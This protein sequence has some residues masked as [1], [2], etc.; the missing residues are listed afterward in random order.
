MNEEGVENQLPPGTEPGVVG[1]TGPNINAKETQETAG[2]APAPL[3]DPKET[4]GVSPNPEDD[5][6]AAT[7]I[8]DE[9]KS[10]AGEPGMDWFE[11]LE[12]DDDPDTE[13]L[14]GE[15]ESVAG[16]ERAMKKIYM[17]QSHRRK[18][19]H[20]D[21][22]WEDCPVLGEG[23]KRKEVVRRS[24]SS[25]GQKDVYYLGP[26]GER[27]RSR[28]ELTTVLQG[29][30]DLTSFDYKSGKFYDGDA[31]P[32]RVRNRVKRKYRERSSSES[33]WM[34]RGDGAETP[35]SYHRLTPTPGPKTSQQNQTNVYTNNVTGA[36]QQG[37]H[38]EE[39]LA[40]EKIRLP[41]P[42]SSRTLPLPSIK[43]EFGSEDS[44]LDC[45]RCGST[46]SGTWYDKQRKRPCCPTCWALSKAKVHPMIRFRKWIPC[47]QCVGCHNSVN[48]GQCA[49][50]KHGLQSPEAKKRLCRK[51]RCMC[52]IRKDP[53]SKF[54]SQMP[55]DD[56]PEMYDDNSNFQNE[57]TDSQPSLKSSDTEN[58]SVNMDL[59]ADL[60]ADFNMDLDE[61]EMSTDDDDDWHKKRK[62]RSCGEC[63]ACLCRKDC[64]TCDFCI[65][66][67]KFGGSNKKR[68]KCRL[69]QCQRQAMRH[70]LPFQMGEIEHGPDGTLPGRPKPQYTYSRKSSFKKNRGPNTSL[71]LTDNEDDEINLQALNHSDYG[72]RNGLPDR[73]PHISNHNYSQPS[74]QSQWDAERSHTGRNA[75]GVEE[76]EED[77]PMITQIFSLADNPNESSVDNENQL[78][79]LLH[80]L[81]LTI[82]PILWYAIMVEGPQLQL[83][84]CSKQSSMA[85]TVVLI[86]PG[87]YYYVTV[88]KQPLLPTHPVYDKFPS[89]LTTATEVVNLLLALERYEVCRGLPPKEAM[90]QG[91][92]IVLERASTCEF[93]VTNKETVCANCR[94]LKRL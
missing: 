30:L 51:R 1:D 84:Q 88:Q 12:D 77:F 20:P 45:A 24:G 63:K 50:C 43:G 69:R 64:G 14:A 65:D 92:P 39:S 74:H 40:E 83:T 93:L 71:D 22:G 25:I 85:D 26:C 78:M 11:P 44:I 61:D 68:Q 13:S 47:G 76:N 52:P 5:N 57:I 16:S 94:A 27:V 28:V 33:S 81:R 3:D 62:R 75:S 42:S 73:A 32:V 58:F 54:L 60:S 59:N 79:K 56:C 19:S 36:Y 4:P 6:P 91:G 72:M 15:T 17:L 38:A 86:N 34:E 46:F 31:P 80:T 23:W 87:F 18:R 7:E 89:R 55:Y 21:E 48:C 8:K 90:L 29:Q 37:S 49:N 70:L 2:E 67:P 35:D 82:M 53:E 9:V 66:K 10:T 41:P